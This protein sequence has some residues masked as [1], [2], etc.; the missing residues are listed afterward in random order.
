MLQAFRGSVLNFVFVGIFGLVVLDCRVL[1]AEPPKKSCAWNVVKT[2]ARIGKKVF[3]PVALGGL[4]AAGG[5]Y[6]ASQ[7]GTVPGGPSP[8]YLFSGVFG[9]FG[10]MLGAAMSY[11][12]VPPEPPAR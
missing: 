3:W 12:H 10:L 11:A 9:S 1:E 5:Y 4:G 7:M 6:M 8:Y 2:S